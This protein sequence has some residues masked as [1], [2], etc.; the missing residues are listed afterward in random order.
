MCDMPFI[1]VWLK[2]EVLMDWSRIIDYSNDVPTNK[3]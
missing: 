3:N 2:I 1:D